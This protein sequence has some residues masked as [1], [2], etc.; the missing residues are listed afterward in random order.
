MRRVINHG[1]KFERG[2]IIC[3]DCGCEFMYSDE[4]V[5]QEKFS[6]FDD[7]TGWESYHEMAVHCPECNH[8]IEIKGVIK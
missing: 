3:S 5:H 1:K 7:E 2:P 6:Y 4:D 8:Q